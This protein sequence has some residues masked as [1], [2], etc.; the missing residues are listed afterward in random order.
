MT[1][2]PVQRAASK[3]IA[4]ADHYVR[5]QQERGTITVTHVPTK[6]MIADLLTKPLVF[7]DFKRHADKLVHPVDLNR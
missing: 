5:E 4:L 3:H 7:A 2:N 1:Y 6:D